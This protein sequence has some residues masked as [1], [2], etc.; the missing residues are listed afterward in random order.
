MCCSCSILSVLKLFI[1]GVCVSCV[2]F[3]ISS[4]GSVTMCLSNWSQR[5]CLAVIC[6]GFTCLL[7]LVISHPVIV[8]CIMYDLLLWL[9]LPFPTTVPWVHGL[10][11][12]QWITTVDP[13]GIKYNFWDYHG[14]YNFL[15]CLF[16]LVFS[17]C[18]CHVFQVSPHLCLYHPCVDFS[19]CCIISS[20]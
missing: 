15:S 9:W 19:Y 4:S 12:S 1:L 18:K 8:T 11:S 3:R 13:I 7:F 16:I 6:V 10:P 5:Y 20:L 17:A 2:C 14:S